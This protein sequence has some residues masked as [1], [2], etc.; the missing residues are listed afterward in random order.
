[1]SS[2]PHDPLL[3]SRNRGNARGLLAIVCWSGTIGLMRSISEALGPVGGPAMYFS[4]SAI[5]VLLVRGVPRPRDLHPAYLWGCGAIFVAYEIFLALAIGYSHT[6]A[7]SLELGMINY[8]WPCL[9]IVAAVLCGQQKSR[10]W[11]WP[12][13]ALSFL[14][15]VWVMKGDGAWSPALLVQNMQSNPVAYAMAFCA[16]GLWAVYSVLS[17][18]YGNAQSGVSLFLMAVAATLWV[19]YLLSDAPPMH[20]TLSSVLQVLLLATLTATGYSCWDYGVQR[21]NLVLLAAA[22]YFTPVLSVLV[23]S[24]WLQTQ[25]TLGFWQGVAMVCAGSLICWQATRSRA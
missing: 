13:A 4:A 17:R 19:K 2:T 5:I 10:W 14:G 9:T 6:R 16:A 11:L 25:P 8:L 1:M 21:G 24:L 3:A 23:A 15:I 12:G 18:R 22:S 7:Q 20:F